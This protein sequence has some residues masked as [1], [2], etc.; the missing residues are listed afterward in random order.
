MSSG[1]E[2]LPD[3]VMRTALPSTAWLSKMRHPWTTARE[4]K[5]VDPATEDADVPRYL[6]VGDREAGIRLDVDPGAVA[7]GIVRG[8]RS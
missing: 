4:S 3:S 6:A 2:L 5:A 1:T 7:G 8:S